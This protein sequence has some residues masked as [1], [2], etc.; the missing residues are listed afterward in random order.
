MGPFVWGAGGAVGGALDLGVLGWCAVDVAA[1]VGRDDDVVV[2]VVVFAAAWMFA[3]VCCDRE[4]SRECGVAVAAVGGMVVVVVLGS[5]CCGVELIHRARIGR[6]KVG[7]RRVMGLRSSRAE[8]RSDLL[9]VEMGSETAWSGRFVY[10]GLSLLLL[11]V[12]GSVLVVKLVAGVSIGRAPES[13]DAGGLCA[14][15]L[16]DGCLLT[17]TLTL[18]TTCLSY[19]GVRFVGSIMPTMEYLLPYFPSIVHHT[20]IKLHVL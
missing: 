4:V 9:I 18:L 19:A 3:V 16:I 2:V 14:N 7:G 13:F 17:V 6:R 10:P 11:A 8:R 15:Y 5:T 1:A 12:L 20:I